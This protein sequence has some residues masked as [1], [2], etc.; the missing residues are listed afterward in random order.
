MGATILM[1][2][3]RK[4][5]W[6]GRS[7]EARRD[8]EWTGPLC[9]MEEVYSACIDK[10]GV[11]PRLFAGPSSSWTG[12]RLLRSDDLG[13]SWQEAKI[14]FPADT[15]ASLERVWQ[16]APGAEQQTVWAGTEPGAVFRSLDGGAT[17]E[18]ERGLWEHPHREEWGA[19]Y[20]GQAFHTVVPH[21]S[22]PDSVVAAISSGGVYATTDGGQSWTAQN[23]GVQAEF[24]PEGQQYPEFGQCVHKIARH[25]AEP[26]RLFMQNHG[27]VYRS[28]DG[29]ATWDSIEK[30]LPS[31]FGFPI[32][33]HPHDPSTVY[34]FP[35]GG[36]GGRYPVGA[37]ARVWRSRDA[38]DTWEEL[39]DGL[40]GGFYAGVMRDAMCADDHETAGIYF[41]ARNGSVWGSADEGDTWT[42]LTSGLPD[43]MVVRAASL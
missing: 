21:P 32:V 22:D 27:G 11:S 13:A 5:L 15:G 28:T 42:E 6:L 1:V 19:G 36:S 10:R 2:G 4:G 24:L 40:P 38:G 23:T 9:D 43:V 35:L 25:P 37:D 16:I 8:W 7:D 17:F 31:N 34:V 39:G 14:G 29:G 30:G 26:D 20:G 3:T 18:L 33:V 41:G 12:P